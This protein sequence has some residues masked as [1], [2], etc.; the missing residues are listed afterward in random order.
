MYLATL[1]SY[2][3]E[4]LLASCSEQMPGGGVGCVMVVADLVPTL[5]GEEAMVVQYMPS[6]FVQF[7]GFRNDPAL[8]DSLREVLPVGTVLP[9][10]EAAADLIR[11]WQS[12]PPAAMPVPVNQLNLPGGGGLMIA[13]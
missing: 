5:P 4:D 9:P 8:G 13:P 11:A 10:Y 7:M 3:L 2:R 6:G 1:N 12:A